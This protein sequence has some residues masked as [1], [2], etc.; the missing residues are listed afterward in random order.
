MH[1]LMCVLMITL[2]PME[3]VPLLDGS[4]QTIDAYVIVP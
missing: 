2:K 1:P 4:S 3:F